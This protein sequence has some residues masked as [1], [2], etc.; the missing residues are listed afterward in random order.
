[1]G[2][3][4]HNEMAEYAFSNVTRIRSNDKEF[5]S[6]ARSMPSMLQVNGMGAA[7]A[8]LCSK[9]KNGNAHE[10]MY[11]IVDQWFQREKFQS[12]GH[13]EGLMKRIVE[14]D[15]D[16]YRLYMIEMM[17]LCQWVKRFAEGMIDGETK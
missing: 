4:F 8:F 11:Q 1:M 5:R 2:K 7:M 12:S 16:T 14:L 3:N 13:K 15:S 6:L 9:K 17:N 10:N